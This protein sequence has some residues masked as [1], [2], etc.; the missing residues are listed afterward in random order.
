[1]SVSLSKN[2]YRLK[3]NIGKTL[4]RIYSEQSDKPF[5]GIFA[6]VQPILVIHDLDLVKKV[7]V[8]SEQYFVD[9]SIAIDENLDPL[10]GKNMFVIKGQRWRRVRVYLSPV[11]TSAKMKMKFYLVEL[12]GK[13][14]LKYLEMV[15]ADCQYSEHTVYKR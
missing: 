5:V 12:C 13:D 10:F 8:K 9:R 14:L 4:E 3:E 15:T 7:L 1:M 11:F 2:P 6:F